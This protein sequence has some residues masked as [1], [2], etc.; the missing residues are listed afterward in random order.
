[1]LHVWWAGV[2]RPPIFGEPPLLFLFLKSFLR[3][4]SA[5][6]DPTPSQGEQ[7]NDEYL[8]GRVEVAY[9]GPRSTATGGSGAIRISRPSS[10]LLRQH[11]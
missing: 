11:E 9:L 5:A 8:E 10:N 3:F 4:V 6:P 1:M 2:H 7:A